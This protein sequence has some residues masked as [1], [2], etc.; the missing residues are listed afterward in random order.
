MLKYR[1]SFKRY[2]FLLV[3]YVVMSFEKAEDY[4]WEL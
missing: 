4:E 3:N 1:F 2:L